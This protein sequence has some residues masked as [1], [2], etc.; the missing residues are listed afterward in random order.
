MMITG[1]DIN[2]LVGR[3][4]WSQKRDFSECRDVGIPFLMTVSIWIF[5]YMER[6]Y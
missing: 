6:D 2:K 1:I 3:K 5:S 4:T